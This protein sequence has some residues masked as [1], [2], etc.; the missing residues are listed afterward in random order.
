MPGFMMSPTLCPLQRF[1]L[2]QAAYQ[3]NANCTIE[4]LSVVLT[5][6]DRSEHRRQGQWN[7]GCHSTE[8][9]AGL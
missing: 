2:R 7:R 5:P 6:K 1:E 4:N 3:L 9:R 8:H